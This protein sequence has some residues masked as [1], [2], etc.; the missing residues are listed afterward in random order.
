MKYL[1]VFLFLWSSVFA[2]RFISKT[3]N[4]AN[5]EP[6]PYVNVGVLNKINGTVSDELGNFTLSLSSLKASDTIKMSSIG[7]KF[8][9]LLVKDVLEKSPSQL[10][11]EEDILD[12]PALVINPKTLKLKKL[13]V[14]TRSKIFQIGF[15]KDLLGQEVG[16]II[17]NKKTALIESV[18]MNFSFCTFDSLVFRV[19]FY[20]FENLENMKNILT[21]PIIISISKEE[22]L[23]RV[24]INLK[25][26]NVIL[27]GDFVL[28]IEHI[29]QLGKGELFIYGKIGGKSVVKGTSQSDSELAPVRFSL[30]VNALVEQ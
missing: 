21:K 30:G 29:K 12:L 4:K 25:E 2:Q 3:L 7:F 24:E 23:K 6:I 27:N 16:V 13:G 8:K 10:F 22:A 19:N 15:A 5:N 18:F 17:K 20:E 1:L 26:Y 11:L 28:S 9:Y 14:D